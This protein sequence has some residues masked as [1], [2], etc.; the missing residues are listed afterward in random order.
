MRRLPR[1]LAAAASAVALTA[2]VAVPAAADTGSLGSVGPGSAAPDLG[3]SGSLGTWHTGSLGADS[4]GAKAPDMKVEQDGHTVKVTFGG[5]AANF[6]CLAAAV[7]PHLIPSVL[8]G[9]VL[10]LLG[11]MKH[12]TAFSSTMKNVPSG[13]YA[14]IGMCPLSSGLANPA[15]YGIAVPSGPLGSIEGP[16]AGSIDFGSAALGSA[17][18]MLGSS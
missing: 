3:V 17:E 15:I 12:N 6:G 1:L 10:A 16:V 14:V 7:P 9:D 18:N 4:L 5:F 2:A 11:T 8:S 13:V